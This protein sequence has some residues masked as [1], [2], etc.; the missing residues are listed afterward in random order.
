[1]KALFTIV[2]TLGDRDGTCHRRAFEGSDAFGH[3]LASRLDERA[4]GKWAPR[5]RHR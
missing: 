1:L 2:L 5:R 3:H 4:R